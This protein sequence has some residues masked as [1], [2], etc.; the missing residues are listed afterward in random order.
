MNTKSVLHLIPRAVVRFVV[1]VA[2][3]RCCSPALAASDLVLQL[4]QAQELSDRGN[5]HAAIEIL[6][7]IVH[8]RP[9]G[10]GERQMA[11]AWNI[12]GSSYQGLGE[13]QIARQS[14][15]SAIRL[16]Q[17]LPTAED[18]FV[19]SL[20]DLASLSSLE[21]QLDAAS[22]LRLKARKIYRNH[23]DW[24]GRRALTTAWLRLRCQRTT[25]G[26]LTSFSGTLGTTRSIRPASTIQIVQKCMLCVHLSRCI[27]TILQEQ[28]VLT[29]DPSSYGAARKGSHST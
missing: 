2:F 6:D 15:E 3:L 29:K 24:A 1:S 8:S 19:S 5:E 22:N 25:C 23:G 21:G 17:G 20:N 10:L 9:P 16:V 18:I 12:L 26:P 13:Y 11:I 27:V 28:S 4:K 7:P 14:Y